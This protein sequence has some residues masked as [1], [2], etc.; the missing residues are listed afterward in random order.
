MQEGVGLLKLHVQSQIPAMVLGFFCQVKQFYAQ[1]RTDACIAM[2][3]EDLL[4]KHTSFL[5]RYNL[6]WIVVDFG[7]LD[8]P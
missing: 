7:F 3:G 8:E 2:G 1:N 5:E 4:G 6:V